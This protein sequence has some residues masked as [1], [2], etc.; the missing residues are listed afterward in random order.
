MLST[1]LQ[2]RTFAP[3]SRKITIM[4]NL[5]SPPPKRTNFV[6]NIKNNVPEDIKNKIRL[7]EVSLGRS[8]V[9]GFFIG[10]AVINVYNVSFLS[11]LA[12]EKYLVMA[13]VCLMGCV[14][15]IP[16]Y[17]TGI[18]KKEVISELNMLRFSMA[19]MSL[20]FL[21]EFIGNTTMP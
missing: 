20:L 9:V 14:T 11:Q 21:M 12:H 2:P 4:A 19:S 10:T 17:T 16:K 7:V 6:D 8:S 18:T 3:K 5:P 15:I 13:L 1:K